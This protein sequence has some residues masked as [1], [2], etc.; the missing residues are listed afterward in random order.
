MLDIGTIFVSRTRLGTQR[1]Q[2]AGKSIKFSMAGNCKLKERR[3]CALAKFAVFSL[4]LISFLFQFKANQFYTVIFLS[5]VV[6]ST[7]KATNLEGC[8]LRI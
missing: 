2:F 7:L 5:I 6:L 1:N 3:D 8:C 4:F